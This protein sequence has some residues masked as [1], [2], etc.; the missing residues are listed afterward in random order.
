LPRNSTLNVEE[1][2]RDGGET[3]KSVGKTGEVSSRL[4][5]MGVWEKIWEKIQDR[6]LKGRE[7]F[8]PI[9]ER[10]YVGKKE[11]KKQEEG[12]I[13]ILLLGQ[14]NYYS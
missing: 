8:P 9:W 10:K 6:I 11:K 3:S 7:I 13:M 5:K 14:I 2:E 4:E 12:L 1:G